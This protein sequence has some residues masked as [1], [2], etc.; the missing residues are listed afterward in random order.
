ME[1]LKGRHHIEDVRSRRNYNINV[2]YKEE[3]WEVVC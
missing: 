2:S 1:S 3:E